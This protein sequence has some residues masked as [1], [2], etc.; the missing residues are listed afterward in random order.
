MYSRKAWG[1]A[2]EPF[3][4]TKFLKAPDGTDGNPIVSLV[5]YEWNDYD[6]I[7]VRPTPDSKVV[8]ALGQITRANAVQVEFICDQENVDNK[9]CNSTELGQ[10][11]LTSNATE[12][13]KNPII[14]QAVNL[15][16]PGQPVNYPIKKTGYYCIGTYAFT[17]NDYSA[18]V[19]FRNAYGELPAA[20]IAKLPF[21][22]GLTIAYA[23]IGAY[24]L[25][26]L[27]RQ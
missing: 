11:I 9:I 25:P 21:Y 4:L 23:V 17:K 15:N 1:G 27:C 24:V 13:S 6:L 22:G 7:G 2:V 26:C 8:Q 12:I 16:D 20:Q 14:T 19:E 18:V 5:I 3:I 10:F